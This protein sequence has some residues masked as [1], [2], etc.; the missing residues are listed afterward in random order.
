M[1]GTKAKYRTALIQ[2]YGTCPVPAK[3][4]DSFRPTTA[5]P[6]IAS[7]DVLGDRLYPTFANRYDSGPPLYLRR[8][9]DT[10]SARMRGLDS[11]ALHAEKNLSSVARPL[12]LN[13]LNE[14]AVYHARTLT[15]NSWWVAQVTSRTS[16]CY[17]VPTNVFVVI[18]VTEGI[19]V[20][21]MQAGVSTSSPD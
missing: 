11:C 19:P 4:S 20:S 5:V 6:K 17:A 21:G 15:L 7:G 8:D 10:A 18:R 9:G 14:G 1:Y 13:G 12:G 3:V 16:C 2:A